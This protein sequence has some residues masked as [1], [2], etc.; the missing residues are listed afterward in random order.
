LAL[1]IISLSA[2]VG[3]IFVFVKLSSLS[4]RL[5]NIDPQLEHIESAFTVMDHGVRYEFGLARD[6]AGANS[7]LLRE[8]ITT[9]IGSLSINTNTS[10]AALASTEK[11]LL[12]A[13]GDR[14]NEMKAEAA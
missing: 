10:I 5:V 8:E 1:I 2:V 14:L 11:S 3:M 9:S 12:E 13:F 6:A 7:K 4:R